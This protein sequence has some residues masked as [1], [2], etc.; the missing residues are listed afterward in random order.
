M[1][2]IRVFVPASIGN[3]GPGF[4]V[5]GLAVDGLGD[6]IEIEKSGSDIEIVD[7]TGRDA[8]DIPREAEKNTASIAA[9]AW[10]RKA[11]YRDGLKIKIHRRLPVSGGLGA[12]ATSAVGGAFATAALYGQESDRQSIMEAALTAEEQ[13]AG[14][15]LDN[16]APSLFGGL[17][18]SFSTEPAK[19]VPVQMTGNWWLVTVTPDLR[20]NTKD[21]REVLPGQLSTQNWVKQMAH[22]SS[23][24]VAFQSGDQE[25]MRLALVDPF[26]EVYRSALIPG[27]FSV[28][29]SAIA[30]GALGCS[31]S[32]GGPTIFS[33]C[34]NEQSAH[35]IG[36]AM[37]SG[38]QCEAQVHVGQVAKKGAMII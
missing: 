14:R 6:E 8:A 27:F 36:E 7:I 33:I 15:H 35:E 13:V 12:S 32:G 23:L 31:I 28:K 22:T 4:D 17:T 16:I 30:A 2:P 18:I 19:V 25:T 38:F 20:V 34:A 29:K 21:S 26:A 9:A 3:V 1:T 24:I 5:L 37:R 11:G 10:M